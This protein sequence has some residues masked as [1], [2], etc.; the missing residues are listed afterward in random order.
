MPTGSATR[1]AA[2][3][4]TY[5]YLQNPA[6]VIPLM[7]ALLT[8]KFNATLRSYNDQNGAATWDFVIEDRRTGADNLSPQDRVKTMHLGDVAVYDPVSGRVSVMPLST[9]QTVYSVP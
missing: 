3:G 1:K 8:I 5:Y 2:S 6:D 7:Q 4:N 9:F